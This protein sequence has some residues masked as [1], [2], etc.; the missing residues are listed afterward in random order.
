MEEGEGRR[1]KGEECVCVW[2]GGG[3][4]HKKIGVEKDGDAHGEGVVVPEPPAI[5]EVLLGLRLG[6]V[7][8]GAVG[9]GKDAEE[10]GGGSGGA[11]GTRRDSHGREL[12]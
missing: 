11:R 7:A 2:G 12:M 3:V 4:T 8:D 5:L 10:E 9:E 6:V 1:D